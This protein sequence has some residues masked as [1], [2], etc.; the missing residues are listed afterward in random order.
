MRKAILC[1]V[2]AGLAFPLLGEEATRVQ[3]YGY[4]G[5]MGA[6]GGTTFG[7]LLNPGVGADLFLYKGLAASMDIGYV[8]YYNNFRADGVGVFSPNVA[9]HFFNS[10]RVVPFVTAGYSMT[11]RGG[12][13]NLGNYGAGLTY[14]FSNRVGLRVEGRDHCNTSGDHIAGIRIGI[15]IR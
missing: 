7:K 3:G 10:S 15:T 13:T 8:G 12:T 14:W 11:F 4:F 9:Y 2:C 5:V 1:L 6:T